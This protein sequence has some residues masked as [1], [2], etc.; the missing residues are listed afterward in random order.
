MDEGVDGLKPTDVERAYSNFAPWYDL[1]FEILFNK[2][3]RFDEEKYR[4]KA[5]DAL[6]LKEGDRVLDI[7]CGTGRNFFFI[8]RQIG[9]S[10]KIVGLDYTEGM[11]EVAHNKVLKN[12]WKN[13][14]L[15]QGDA[16]NMDEILRGERFDG[17]ISTFC[18]S[19]V[20][21]WDAAIK[22]ACKLLKENKRLVILDFKKFKGIY[23]LL[24]PLFVLIAGPFSAGWK[25]YGGC[26]D[27]EN[28]M[29]KWLH[30]VTFEEYYLGKIVFLTFGEKYR[31]ANIC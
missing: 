11:L 8:Q 10:G 7:G 15:I 16:Q 14:K 3:L 26:R 12:N 30:H 5:V 28:K 2:L 17:I 23:S 31:A 4:M 9:P 27:W 22:G 25:D 19:I 6:N 29:R 1:S 13:V 24:N 18:L 21:K 20:P